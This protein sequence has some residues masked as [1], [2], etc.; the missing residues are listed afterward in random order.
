MHMCD[1]KGAPPYAQNRTACNCHSVEKTGRKMRIGKVAVGLVEEE[2][3]I[4]KTSRI[5]NSGKN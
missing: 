1:M 3:L 4:L 2:E 5:K